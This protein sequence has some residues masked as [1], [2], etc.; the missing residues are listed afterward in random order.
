MNS[1]DNNVVLQCQKAQ[2]AYEFSCIRY[3]HSCQICSFYNF[4]DWFEMESFK[5]SIENITM[6]YLLKIIWYMAQLYF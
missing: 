5:N 4:Y 1:V 6:F 3:Q 2:H